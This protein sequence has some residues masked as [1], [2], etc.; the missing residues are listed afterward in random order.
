MKTT[1]RFV[2]VVLAAVICLLPRTSW[3]GGTSQRVL[4]VALLSVTPIKADRTRRYAHEEF[5]YD[6]G[7]NAGT[8][9]VPY[10]WDNRFPVEPTDTLLVILTPIRGAAN[11]DTSGAIRVFGADKARFK[12]APTIE[13]PWRTELR[14]SDVAQSGQVIVSGFFKKGD[15]GG[16][17]AW[18]IINVSEPI[19]VEVGPDPAKVA[20]AMDAVVAT[21]RAENTRLKAEAT[22][23][24]RQYQA[25]LAQYEAQIKALQCRP[26][27]VETKVETRTT[28]KTGFVVILGQPGQCVKVSSNNK[29]LDLTIGANGFA[30]IAEIPVPSKTY[31]V[32]KPNQTVCLTADYLIGILRAQGGD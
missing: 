22:E 15:A 18:V 21:A 11:K 17:E 32:G 19:K 9:A 16:D 13:K 25:H 6:V 2:V 20:A 23:K 8:R 30:G 3:A 7:G 12:G 4:P 31:L 28:P 29:L 5:V 26:D 27:R 10:L 14:L 24:D 1:I